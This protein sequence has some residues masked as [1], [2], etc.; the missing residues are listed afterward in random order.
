LRPQPGMGRGEPEAGLCT[1]APASLEQRRLL[2]GGGLPSRL[3]RCAARRSN[4]T[5]RSRARS[6]TPVA[7]AL[8]AGPRARPSSCRPAPGRPDGETR[9]GRDAAARA[10]ADCPRLATRRSAASWQ[11][12][13]GEERAAADAALE[14]FDHSLSDR[15]AVERCSRRGRLHRGSRG[16]GG[17]RGSGSAPFCAISTRNVLAACGRGRRRRRSGRRADRRCLQRARLAGTKLPACG[18]SRPRA[19]PDG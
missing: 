11:I 13:R 4:P 2:G 12:A 15:Q 3:L 18:R 8:P 7:H 1:L 5:S 16:C 10:P 17:V 9:A 14:V 19:R 6:I